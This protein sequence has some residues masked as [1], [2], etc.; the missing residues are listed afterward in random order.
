MSLGHV[1]GAALVTSMLFATHLSAPPAGLTQT[2]VSQ[3]ACW[4]P[5]ADIPLTGVACGQVQALQLTCSPP[6]DIV[7][8]TNLNTMQRSADI[9]SWQEFIALNWPALTGQRGAPDPGK[10]I[11]DPGA[12]VW[13]TWKEESEVFRPDGVAPE[14]WDASERVPTSCAGA[15]KQ[16]FRIQ[17]IDDIVDESVQAAGATDVLPATLTD[18]RG[19]LVR[20]EIR[21]NKV[22][23]D[24]IVQNRLYDARVQA[25]AKTIAFPS[26]A[27]LVKAAWREVTPEEERSYH[28]VT[29]CVCDRDGHRQPIN[30]Q[31][32][33]MG[34]VGLHI[35]QKT[36]SS[37]QWIW[38]TFEQVD[39]VPGPGT[40]THPA[41]YD[42][43]CPTCPKN[44]QTRPG[45]PNQITRLTPIP[46]S[47]PNCAQPQQAVDNVQ[48]LNADVRRALTGAGTVFR[49]YQ[50]VNTQFPVPPTGT[51]PPTAFTVR[52]PVLA[53]TTMESFVQR[54]STC[55]GCHAT[56]RTVNPTTFV[57]SDFTFTLNNAQ[58]RLPNPNVIAP[59]SQPVTSWD[60][61]NWAA[62]TR[63]YRL[64][65]RTY[66]LLPRNVPR[67]K[68]HCASCHLD[69]GG[70]LTAAWWVNLKQRYATLPALQ[71]RI[72]GCFER[73]MN[74]KPLCAPQGQ[75]TPGNP[76]PCDT[77][78]GMHAFTT[79]MDWLTEQW[80]DPQT[81]THGFP[82]IPSLT[83][84]GANG[85]AIFEQ[86]C[87]VC[88]GADGQGRYENNTYYRPALWGPR[89]FNQAAG[90]FSDPADL[91]A[92]VRWN[93]PLNAGGLLTDQEA[94]DVEAYMHSKPRPVTTPRPV[95][96][97]SKK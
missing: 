54:T 52:P 51:Q 63:G 41:L 50:L 26:G 89:S 85:R 29:A 66:E 40:G 87:A 42:P 69:A 86:K 35:T 32:K 13:E 95:A 14:P 78:A 49:F 94:W 33:R 43:K 75:P 96:P 18:Q 55:M 79:Y 68:L 67:A 6:A 31:S 57:S 62:I 27:M 38:S 72:N 56:A 25:T 17:K 3:P 93:M 19:K 21:M 9:F 97:R 5:S 80:N 20:Y 37:P 4:N 8:A 71:H 53:N 36:P 77:N 58:P 82:S 60:K 15:T 24:Y 48:R 73:S 84:N 10:K 47:E 1:V 30:C 44:R 28:T 92:F 91:A 74:G 65:T 59:P 76:P 61:Q 11:G 2:A 39:N 90:M 88:H 64:T 16:L 22:M 7:T 12:R 70:N 34:L 83:G 23:F 81:T 45:T 46:A